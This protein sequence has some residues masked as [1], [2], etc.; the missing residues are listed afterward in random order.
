VYLAQKKQEKL[1]TPAS[2]SQRL[3]LFKSRKDAFQKGDRED[4]VVVVD[5][6]SSGAKLAYD[7]TR[8][9]YKVVAV[10]T[11]SAPAKVLSMPMPACC[12]GLTFDKVLYYRESAEE[13]AKEILELPYHIVAIQVGCESGVE[14][15]DKLLDI[16]PGYPGNSFDLSE[17][18]RDKYLMGERVRQTGLRA[19][20]QLEV[21]HWD[22]STL[23]YLEEDLGV[24]PDDT[25]GPWCVLKP[26][27]S[28]GSD[29]V[30]IAKCLREAEEAFGRIF[31]AADVFGE[32]NQSV[33][34]Q[35]FLKGTEYVVDSVS[36]EGDHKCVAIWEYEKGPR[37]GASFVY[38]AMRLYQSEDGSREEKMV[39]YMH[40]CLTALGVK[41]GPS[42]GE[43]MWLDGED[44][45][46][47]IE[48]GSRPHGGEGT[49][50]EINE[51]VLGFSQ[52]SA[53]LDSFDKP[54]RWRRLPKRPH[55]F[56]GGVMEYHMISSQEGIL[57]G[58]P[59]LDEV[60]QMR[61][62]DLIEQKVEI[63]GQLEK[64]TD[65]L[66]T[67]GAIMLA[68]DDGRVVEED[69]AAIRRMEDDGT[70]YKIDDPHAM[71][72]IASPNLKTL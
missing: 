46:C 34:V 5:P 13:L 41:N 26:T 66:T 48:V 50:V 36:V 3:S 24:L 32:V 19:V 44:A 45:P 58:L 57:A 27:R 20:K 33:L 69:C 54:Y 64:T 35:E 43:L 17:C 28:A 6:V 51:K 18:R 72:K 8:R 14:Y 16:M 55:R 60:T 40:N 15:Y 25:T 56:A 47:L 67:P 29:G 63:G 12:K 70:F 42:H 65:F 30:Y 1:T 37:N 7:A 10:Y 2:A 62:F 61:S 52:I 71:L 21:K 23:A 4:A 59:R 11:P 39:D 68:H 9:G 31:G 53:M 38:H 22:A 49:Y